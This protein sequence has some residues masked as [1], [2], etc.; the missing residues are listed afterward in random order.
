NAQTNQPK[1]PINSP[2]ERPNKSL[3]HARKPNYFTQLYSP[4]VP[5]QKTTQIHH[6]WK[7]SK[8]QSNPH[9]PR[10]PSFRRCVARICRHA[11]KA[12]KLLQLFIRPAT[13]SDRRNTLQRCDPCHHPL[14]LSKE[15]L[16]VDRRSGL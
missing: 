13:Q 5:K 3:P 15:V 6:S 8:H 11:G 7:R 4:H 16:H 1:V 12:A 9:T 2:H 10:S 14:N